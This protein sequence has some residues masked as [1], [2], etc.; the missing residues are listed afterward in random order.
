MTKVRC[1]TC[2]TDLKDQEELNDHKESEWHSCNWKLRSANILP[3]SEYECY[4]KMKF[5]E[6]DSS[7]HNIYSCCIC[8]KYYKSLN[9]LNAHFDSKKHKGAVK[10]SETKAEKNKKSKICKQS[11]SIF[12]ED[13]QPSAVKPT[14]KSERTCMV[15]CYVC[16]F[17][18]NKFSGFECLHDYLTSEHSSKNPVVKDLNSP[19]Q[20]YSFLMNGRRKSEKPKHYECMPK[21][22]SRLEIFERDKVVRSNPLTETK[23]TC[24]LDDEIIR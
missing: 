20:Y 22:L 3:L 12:F 21:T 17:C 5:D 4:V 8:K 19:D 23:I 2:S 1:Y 14:K 10:L 9:T 18:C 15:P 7:N 16:S 11:K 6:I 24:S 13:Y